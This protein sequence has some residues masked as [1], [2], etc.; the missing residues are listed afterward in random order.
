M[1]LFE[2]PWLELTVLVPLAGAAVVNRVRNPNA[3]S[4]V[5]LAFTGV[6]LAC[7]L[8]AGLGFYANP[9][10]E[11]LRWE[12]FPAVF[13]GRV[14]AVDELSAPLLP[15]VALLHFLT[16]VATT[17]TKMRRFS[18]TWSLASEAQRM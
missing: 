17:R 12:L 2:I 13:G 1:N 6:S 9:E 14:L 5:C 15:L 18:F 3:A 10:G 16:T 8:L 7:S 4:R 11:G